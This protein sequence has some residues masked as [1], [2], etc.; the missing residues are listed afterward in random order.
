ME[1]PLLQGR[2]QAPGARAR[3]RIRRAIYG[4]GQL[5]LPAWAPASAATKPGGEFVPQSRARELLQCPFS[6]SLHS[7]RRAKPCGGADRN[8]GGV[9][10]PGTSRPSPLQG[11]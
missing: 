6:L 1:L 8:R 9:P 10:L 4:G 7:L 11:G 3:A 2:S 5:M